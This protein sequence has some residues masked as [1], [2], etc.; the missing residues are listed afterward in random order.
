[1]VIDAGAVRVNLADAW[2]WKS[3]RLSADARK[4]KQA[5]PVETK[6]AMRTRGPWHAGLLDYV[7]HGQGVYAHC[8]HGRPSGHSRA[9]VDQFALIRN[10]RKQTLRTSSG[11][12]AIFAAIRR[13]PDVGRGRGFHS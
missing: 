5:H 8:C 9:V 10:S 6:S 1:M 13:G 12:L 11:S 3:K 4:L 2:P 7:S